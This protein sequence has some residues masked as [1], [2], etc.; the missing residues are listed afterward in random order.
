VCKLPQ[1]VDLRIEYKGPSTPAYMKEYDAEED[2]RSLLGLARKSKVGF[3]LTKISLASYDEY[4]RLR[5]GVLWSHEHCVREG[6][7]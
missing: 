3:I 1:L 5:T 4:K 7:I 2:I 6:I